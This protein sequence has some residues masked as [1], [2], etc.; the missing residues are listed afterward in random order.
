MNIAFNRRG[1]HLVYVII[2]QAL[3]HT[4]DL[5]SLLHS[6]VFVCASFLPRILTSSC[7]WSRASPRARTGKVSDSPDWV[8]IYIESYTNW[9]HHHPSSVK[10]AENTGPYKNPGKQW[11]ISVRLLVKATYSNKSHH[12]PVSHGLKGLN[13]FK[14]GC[15]RGV[16]NTFR[17][18]NR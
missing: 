17:M 8:G 1:T 13:K 12:L 7:W 10:I 9:W 14:E 5:C 11:I 6:A 4:L 2:P 15:R 16:V 18:R 3:N